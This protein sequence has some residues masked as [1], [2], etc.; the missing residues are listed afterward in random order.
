MTNAYTG[1]AFI[2]EDGSMKPDATAYCTTAFADSYLANTGE[3]K[4]AAQLDMSIKEMSIIKASQCVDILYGQEFYGI[5][6]SQGMNN[7]YTGTTN[8]AAT[9]E[10]IQGLLFPRFTIIVNNIQVLNTGHM[11]VQLKKAV[12]E[13]AL[14][15]I[16]GGRQD[17]TIYPQPN[18]LPFTKSKSSKVG[19]LAV[20]TVYGKQP[21][22]ERYPGF[23]KVEKILQPILKR[24]TNPTVL[25]F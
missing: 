18:L 2:V 3:A 19:D 4:W 25:T 6:R 22:A 14:M 13:V 15:W 12:C 21:D 11:P 24:T 5:P 7:L 10:Y 8:P 16:N 1:Y 23:W 17:S 20:S 9:G